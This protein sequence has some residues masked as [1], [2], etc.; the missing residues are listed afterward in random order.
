MYD[1]EY[2]DWAV[3][4]QETQK[5]RRLPD[6]IKQPKPEHF[7]SDTILVDDVIADDGGTPV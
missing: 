7:K 2:G 5:D 6:Q 4:D 1:N 3:R